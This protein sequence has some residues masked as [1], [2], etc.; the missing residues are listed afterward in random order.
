MTKQKQET[1]ATV[2]LPRKIVILPLGWVFCGYW[3][4]HNGRVILTE[5]VCI[6]KWGTTAGIGELAI[7][8]PTKDTILDPVGTVSFVT[9]SEVAAIDCQT[10]WTK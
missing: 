6:R 1:E 5:A 7:K 8:G 3:Q 9:G 2:T 10:R 4:Q